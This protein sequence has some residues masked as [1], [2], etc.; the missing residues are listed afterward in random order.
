MKNSR[1]TQIFGVVLVTLLANSCR[2][3]ST[4]IG[5]DQITPT[6]N[7]QTGRMISDEAQKKFIADNGLKLI[8][9][10]NIAPTTENSPASK[11]GS[12][13]IQTLITPE[14][15]QQLGLNNQSIVN[16]YKNK[17]GNDITGVIVNDYKTNASLTRPANNNARAYVK[18]E[19]PVI[20][21]FVGDPDQSQV[22]F[23]GTSIYNATSNPM[24]Y[25]KTISYSNLTSMTNT[26]TLAAGLTVGAKI[27]IT[28]SSPQGSLGLPQGV[29]IP[30]PFISGTAE[31]S[32]E[33]TLNATASTSVVKQISNTITETINPIVP[34]NKKLFVYI[35]QKVQQ[36]SITY[37]IPITYPGAVITK[38][39][40]AYTNYASSFLQRDKTLQRATV[41]YGFNTEAQIYVK[42]LEMNEA[43]PVIH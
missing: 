3:E 37:K 35:V 5:N 28:L 27:S 6:D 1:K 41:R 20:E 38:K 43:T 21:S 14:N 24:T 40:D 30:L 18:T 33:A 7:Q 42:E 34:P 26:I 15:L 4:E 17:F 23:S 12:P 19:L 11:E 8:G 16:I 31:A 10:I 29:S 22:V 36:G 32:I 9:T 2:Q 13:T 39:G 25:N